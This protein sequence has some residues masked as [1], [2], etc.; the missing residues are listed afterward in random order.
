MTVL[1]TLYKGLISLLN[2]GPL[3]E[4]YHSGNYSKLLTASG[5]ISV[6]SPILPALFVVEII[7]AL[8]YKRF[9]IDDYKM[10]LIIRVVNHFIARFISLSAVGFF[11]GLFERYAIFKTSFTWY[12]FIYGY[13]VWEFAHFVFHYLGHK[14]RI[15]WCLH[16]IHHTPQG[17]NLSV[18]YTNFFLEGPYA[19]VV[20]TTICILLGVNP[21]L[22][23]FIMALD[24]LWSGFTH[25]GENIMKEGRMGF[26][27]NFILTPAHHRVH[28]A[29]NPLYMDTNFCNLLNIWDR[30]FRTYQVEDPGT[31]IEYGITRPV[32][33]KNFLDVYFGEF[34]YLWLDI[35]RAPGLLNKV[36]YV[37]MPPGWDHNGEHKTAARIKQELKSGS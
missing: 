15:F 5:I 21:V 3:L 20:R 35:K 36:L 24:G 32:D 19:D 37:F 16:S 1:N 10:P 28:H 13:V 7:R 4:M 33:Q 29:R 27:D 30:I 11:I 17:M 26:L 8:L 14:V 34:Y 6:L 18:A 23:L 22:L 31:K 25:V 9:R 2:L 12:W